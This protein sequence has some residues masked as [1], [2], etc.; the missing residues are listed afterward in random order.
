[1]LNHPHICTIYDVG[2]APPVSTGGAS[3]PAADDARL[4]FIVMELL[5]GETLQQRL[6]HGALAV[7]EILDTGI[8]LADGLDAAH[9]AGIIHRDLKPSNI[10]LT[11]KGPKILDLGLAKTTPPGAGAIPDMPTRTGHAPL[12]DP[13]VAV[14]TA[15]YMSPE[16]LRGEIRAPICSPSAQS[17]TRWPPAGPRFP[18]RR[19]R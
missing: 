5:E 16:Q 7:P 15:A 8:A 11:P 19:V 6:A 13:G 14:G 3:A 9:Q 10:L 12:T 1:V 17:S 4:H 18:V 2:D